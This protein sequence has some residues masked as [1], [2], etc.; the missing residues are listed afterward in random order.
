MLFLANS[1]TV[2]HN[3]PSI[4]CDQ[5]TAGVFP[6]WTSTNLKVY[7]TLAMRNTFIQEKLKPRSPFNPGL[8]LIGF[9]T[10][11]PRTL[12]Y[13]TRL[14]RPKLRGRLLQ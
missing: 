9:R 11:Q 10:T 13:A 8:V 7:K 14:N 1:N 2:F 5:R 4:T 6:V 12:P 3:L